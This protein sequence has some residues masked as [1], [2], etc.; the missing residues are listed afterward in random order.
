VAAWARDRLPAEANTR[1]AEVFLADPRAVLL[2]VPPRRRRHRPEPTYTTINLLE[3]EDSLLALCRQGR[4]EHGGMPR[5]PVGPA[6]VER[7]ITAAGSWPPP[8]RTCPS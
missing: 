2:D 4:V 8:P 6:L 7:A 1:I 3:T 5:A